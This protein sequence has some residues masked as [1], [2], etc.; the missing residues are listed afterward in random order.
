MDRSA[1]IKLISVTQTQDSLKVWHD[2]PTERQVYC[3][4]SSISQSEWFEGGRVGLNPALRFRMFAP[5]Y[6]G[7]KVLKYNGTEYSVYRTY[8]D[9]N[10]TIDLYTEQR[11]G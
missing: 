10:E 3:E 7:E 4:V 6:Q 9:R 2:T 8:V 1:T 11:R 5:D